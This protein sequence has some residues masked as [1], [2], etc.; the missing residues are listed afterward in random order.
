MT[1]NFTDDNPLV[2]NVSLNFIDNSARPEDMG[3]A[4][5]MTNVYEPD[6]SNL[7]S[8]FSADSYVNTENLAY[9][10]GWDPS[11]S[12]LQGVVNV[13]AHELTHAFTFGALGNTTNPGTLMEDASRTTAYDSPTPP[14]T[15]DE[16]AQLR[17]SL[18]CD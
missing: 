12:Y 14:L 1:V 16:I 17:S 18:G 5:G 10:S 13:A 15:P 6:A 7:Y 9:F 2:S 3:S 8:S 4:P 11:G